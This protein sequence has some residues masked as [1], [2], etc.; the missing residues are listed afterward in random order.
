MGVIYGTGVY[1]KGERQK[2]Q[3]V[4]DEDYRKAKHP[5][6]VTKPV[7]TVVMGGENV[8]LQSAAPGNVTYTSKNPEICDV[9]VVWKD[10]SCQLIPKKAGETIVT[11][12][13]DPTDHYAEG[14]VDVK[15]IVKERDDIEEKITLQ[16]EAGDGGSIAAVDAATG[17]ILENGAKIKPNAEVQFTASPNSGYSVKNWTINGEVYKENG[18][19]YTGTTMKYAITAS[20]GIVKVEF[21]KDEV[22][23]VKGDVNL[24]GK[25]EIGD[26]REAL[27]SICKKTQLTE[28]QKQAGDIN[29]N[30]TVDIE[31]LRTILRVVCGKVESL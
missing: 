27:R 3:Y 24:N 8:F 9:Q 2:G 5:I 22:E 6:A 11:V 30:G 17:K 20:S 23:V 14:A 31:D 7:M 16:Y 4:F 28:T 1:E 25:V 29:K 18:Q 12:H 26:V 15:V 10:E 13:A 19:V 21:V